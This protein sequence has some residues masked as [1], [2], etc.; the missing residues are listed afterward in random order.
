VSHGYDATPGFPP[1]ALRPKNAAVAV[2]VKTL[3][4]LNQQVLRLS[5]IALLLT[6]CVLTYSVL[7]RY[8]LKSSTD[9]QDEASVFMLVGATFMS[10]AYVQSLRGHVGIEALA[11]LLPQ[12]VNT[13]RL[14][15]VD[16]VSTLFCAFFSW[17]SWALFH[18]AWS[19]GQT[20]SSSF[21]PPLWIPYSLM[22]V[23]MSLLAI[24]LLLQSA[25]RVTGGEVSE[26]PHE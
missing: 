26:L 7:T 1:G 21:A 23:G 19:E 4:G 12:S 15:L 6:S 20:T 14:I 10:T 5:M 2:L 17:K 16:F 11:T 9:W 18:E 8:F 22:A 25:V 3:N 13:V 24:Q